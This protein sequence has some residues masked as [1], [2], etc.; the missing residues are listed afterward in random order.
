MVELCLDGSM[1]VGWRERERERER[2]GQGGLAAAALMG[3]KMRTLLRVE[4]SVATHIS[5]SLPT[6]GYIFGGN[7]CR[8]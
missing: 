6:M 8:L 5:K 7:L 1:G 3:L 2:V 4:L